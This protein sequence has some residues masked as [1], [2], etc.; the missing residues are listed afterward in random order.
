MTKRKVTH[1][2]TKG[3]IKRNIDKKGINKKGISTK[4]AIK[5][6]DA[7]S[8]WLND[9]FAAAG[10]AGH[11]MAAWN[12]EVTRFVGARLKSGR[13]LQ[14]SLT[15]CRS[16]VEA[17]RLQHAWAQRAA[18]DYIDEG[19]RLLQIVPAARISRRDGAPRTSA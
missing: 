2:V 10:Q 14:Q 5:R 6:P 18:Q 11:V 1:R 16:W 15:R 17:L 12:G 9:S 7:F 13:E 3:I 19:V 8:G 4:V